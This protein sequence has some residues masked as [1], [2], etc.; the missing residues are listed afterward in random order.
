MEFDGRIVGNGVIRSRVMIGWGTCCTNITC[1]YCIFS[2]NCLSCRFANWLDWLE[3]AIIKLFKFCKAIV[4]CEDVELSWEMVT[5]NPS[6]LALSPYTIMLRLATL[7]FSIAFSLITSWKHS[8][9]SS[10]ITFGEEVIW[11]MR[12]IW[13]VEEVFWIFWEV[14]AV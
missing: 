3:C 4:N 12:M 1:V 9:I 10:M 5:S 8:F 7:T 13:L 11:L 6:S 14:V 2:V